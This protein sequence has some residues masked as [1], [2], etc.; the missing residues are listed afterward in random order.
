[1]PHKP[2]W[3]EPRLLDWK[4]PFFRRGCF[5]DAEKNIVTHTQQKSTCSGHLKLCSG[6][7]CFLAET[8]QSHVY[9]QLLLIFYIL[10]ASCCVIRARLHSNEIIKLVKASSKWPFGVPFVSLN[11]PLLKTANVHDILSQNVIYYLV[12]V[13]LLSG[14]IATQ[15]A[16]RFQGRN[17]AR[18]GR[19]PL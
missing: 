13:R 9:T 4:I 10:G 11:Q 19:N 6:S 2:A 7:G 16:I 1:M 8:G 17:W 12:F 14:D 15:T 3:T 18:L 5:N